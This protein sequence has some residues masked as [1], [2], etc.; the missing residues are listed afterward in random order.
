M[1]KKE[2]AEILRQLEELYPTAGTELVYKDPYE[3][4]VAVILSAQCTDVRV[5]RVTAEL[6]KK[7][8]TP[9]SMLT[10]SQIE[11]EKII[12]SCGFYRNKAKN[13]LAASAMILEQYNGEVPQTLE[14]LRT[15]PGVGRKTANVV[16][17]IA[18]GI[19][20]IAVDTHVFRVSNRIGL[21]TAKDELGTEL[22]LMRLLPKEQ[23]LHAHHL[24]LWH[25]RRICHSQRPKCDIC[26]IRQHCRYYK[27]FDK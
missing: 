19:P 8:N 26:P 10:L 1:T 6:Y 25:G 3:L 17:A 12:Y 22:A 15:L 7:Y 16:G 13:I 5:N 4:L 21:A 24:I 9:E 23:W 20:A 27:Q 14:E 18:F 2:A 11:L